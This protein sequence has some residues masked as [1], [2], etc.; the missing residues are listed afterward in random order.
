MAT[1]RKQRRPGLRASRL[2]IRLT[3]ASLAVIV[4]PL[5][6]V[7]LVM[8]STVRETTVARTFADL[9]SVA[10]LALAHP[11]ADRSD[12]GLGR[13]ALRHAAI[14]GDERPLPGER[15]R[16]VT[17][18]T[19]EG[20]VLADSHSDPGTM[21]NHADRPEIAEA[22]RS[23]YG[24]SE[25]FSETR[26]EDLTYV[27]V[28]PAWS[29]DRVVRFASPV[30][31][32]EETTLSIL[33]P[34]ALIAMLVAALATA[35]S[36]WFAG[37][38]SGRIAQIYRFSERVAAGDFRP[39]EVSP[40]MDELDGLVASLNRTAGRLKESFE[41]LT[42][43]RNQGAAILSSMDEGVAVMDPDLRILY[44]NSAFRTLLELPGDSW[45]EFE[46]RK[47]KRTLPAPRMVRMAKRALKG[48]RSEVEFS[49]AGREILVRAAPVRASLPGTESAE[50]TTPLGAVLVLTDVT[51]LHQLERVRRDFV[52]N[53]SH[54]LKTPLTSIQGFAETLMAGGIDSD[55]QRG[56]F[57]SRIHEHAVRLSR[58]TDD[59][60]RLARMES[61]R[62]EPE[63][64]PVRTRELAQSVLDSARVKSGNRTLTYREDPEV[65]T[66][67]T[68]PDLLTEVLH[69]LVDNA[70]QYSD[71]EGRIEVE[72]GLAEKDLI[73]LSV[74][75]DGVG[76]PAK[77]RERIF[78]RFY[79][80][81]QARS[82][83]VG[84]TGLG[85]AIAKHAVELLGGRMEV[86]S[87]P[88]RGSRFSVF[89]PR[90]D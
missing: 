8:A 9:D 78:E 48:E 7:L 21:D 61:G 67:H 38:F 28:R 87:K 80:V 33:T 70:V 34:V 27:A 51:E 60:L 22:F 16:R 57:L 72:A 90:G 81:D 19:R 24:R 85:L 3:L 69:N 11:P 75:D 26:S 49:L 17:L 50:E 63:M 68:D 88:E 59:L 32:I 14:L 53:L 89:L 39:A 55:E 54:E 40:R 2:A 44:L 31:L 36:F 71:D 12:E 52:A 77:H 83:E 66:L 58:I 35:T 41:S 5:L 42:A 18:V 74:Q 15:D 43:E 65:E 1:S 13:W 64:R 25:R 29:P 4:V 6:A 47:V 79:R 23:G 82:R 30:L 62:H 37:R 20:V 86:S 56:R 73:C 10:D 76:I 84:G 46:G 45:K